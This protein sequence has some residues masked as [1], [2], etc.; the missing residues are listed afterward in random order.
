MDL[1][2][3]GV[4]IRADALRRPD[5]G[6]LMASP[7]QTGRCLCLKR[8]EPAATQVHCRGVAQ[9]VE[10]RS[11]KP[12]V[13]G[14]SPT[15]PAKYRIDFSDRYSGVF[16]IP[17]V[18]VILGRPWKL[19]HGTSPR[20]L[21]LRRHV[22]RRKE[23]IIAGPAQVRP[24]G[25][26]TGLNAPRIRHIGA[27]EPKRVRGASVALRLGALSQSGRRKRGKQRGCRAP[28][29]HVMHYHRGSPPHCQTGSA[30]QVRY[31]S[32]NGRAGRAGS[33]TE[34]GLRRHL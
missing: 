1:S 4:Q 9:L 5:R 24:G 30:Y 13:V 28:A 14:S 31:A 20:A 22:L 7:L 33:R 2:A 16:G 34:H 6:V 8:R 11:P 29:A 12:V 19:W 25:S 26:K 27:A 18:V 10:Y 15:A 17:L 3:G 32:I 21:L 23:Y